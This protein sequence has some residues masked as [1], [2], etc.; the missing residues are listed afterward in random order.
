M[1]GKAFLGEFSS[2]A[3]NSSQSATNSRASTIEPTCALLR[4]AIPNYPDPLPSRVTK[5]SRTS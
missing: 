1:R 4:I 2:R 5:Q 3:K